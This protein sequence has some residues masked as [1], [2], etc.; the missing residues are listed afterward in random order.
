MI[1]QFFLG[2]MD[3]THTLTTMETTITL[4][5]SSDLQNET[6]PSDQSMKQHH[7]QKRLLKSQKISLF[8]L[9]LCIHTK[10]PTKPTPLLKL[11]LL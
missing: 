7:L 11:T 9:L 3:Y 10:I 2:P 8:S 1:L 6:F 4:T 5:N